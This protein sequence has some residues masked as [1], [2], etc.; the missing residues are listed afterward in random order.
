VNLRVGVISHQK[1]GGFGEL[2]RHLLLDGIKIS[3]SRQ[4]EY[5]A[6][7]D[8]DESGITGMRAQARLSRSPEKV[9]RKAS[10]KALVPKEE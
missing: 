7:M 5:P 10:L 1:R 3:S 8:A 9:K 4:Q 6:E 2:H